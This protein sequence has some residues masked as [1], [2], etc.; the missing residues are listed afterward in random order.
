M[1]EL[2]EKHFEAKKEPGLY[3]AGEVISSNLPCGGYNLDFAWNTAIAA[4]SRAAG[5]YNFSH[6]ETS[7]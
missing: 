6:R 1:T 5:F 7:L 4:A 2:D 3:F